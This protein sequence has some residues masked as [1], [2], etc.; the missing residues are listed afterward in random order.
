MKQAKYF[1]ASWCGPCKLFKPIIKELIDEGYP[2]EI[3]D[4]DTNESL[5]RELNIR[6]VPTTIIFSDGVEVERFMGAKKKELI[7]TKLGE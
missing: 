2:I 6:S 3:L 7:E 4:I 1:T 5:A